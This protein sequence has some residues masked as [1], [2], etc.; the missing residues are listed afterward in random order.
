MNAVVRIYCVRAGKTVLPVRV[1]YATFV[2]EPSNRMADK[3]S[4]LSEYI[5]MYN[6]IIY[7]I[8][9]YYNLRSGF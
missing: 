5:E 3:P 1:Q 4:N 8:T 6:E 7:V 2:I 9:N